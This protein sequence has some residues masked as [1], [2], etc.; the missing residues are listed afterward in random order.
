M[1][2]E[3]AKTTASRGFILVMLLVFITSMGI[4]LTMALPMVST[5]VQRD[6]ARLLV[7]DRAQG[8]IRHD[9]FDHLNNYL[10]AN[11][12]PI[13]TTGRNERH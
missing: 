10:P 4:F 11:A 7:I 5:D 12:H 6:Q 2:E 8:S 3:T 1:T 13:G 9:T